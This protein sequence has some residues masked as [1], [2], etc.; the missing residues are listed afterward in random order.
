MC[1]L[2]RW[3]CCKHFHCTWMN[4]RSDSCGCSRCSFLHPS[5]VPTPSIAARQPPTGQIQCR[6][7]EAEAPRQVAVEMALMVQRCFAPGFACVG[8]MLPA[9]RVEARGRGYPLLGVGT[10]LWLMWGWQCCCMTKMK[11]A[12]VEWHKEIGYGFDSACQVLDATSVDPVAR[13]ANRTTVQ[14]IQYDARA[15]SWVSRP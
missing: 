8:S 13:G 15:H 14:A 9:R 2:T 11:E 1:Y 6:K 12:C 3:C 10:Y 7:L 5:F 4:P